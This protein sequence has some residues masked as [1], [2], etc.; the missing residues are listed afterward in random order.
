M[1][2]IFL[3]LRSLGTYIKLKIRYGS[4]VKLP[5]INSIRGKFDVNVENGSVLSI[6][7]FIRTMGPIYLT[8][9]GNGKLI[10]G[11]HN[12]FN[13]NICITCLDEITIGNNCMFANNIVI[14]D[15]NHKIVNGTPDHEAFETDHVV[16]G[17]DVWCGA[18]V[19]ICRGVT[20]GDKAVIGANSV[21]TKD[22]PSGETWCGCPAREINRS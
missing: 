20:I 15:H 21:V 8:V 2:K 17:N 22:V 3:G 13:H 19:T 12:F 18:N 5:V 9:R 16:I 11:S 1:K 6:N 4:R 14:V 7:G 10:I